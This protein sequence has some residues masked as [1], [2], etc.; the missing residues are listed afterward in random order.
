MNDSMK[1]FLAS[2]LAFSLIFSLLPVAPPVS[3]SQAGVENV[4]SNGDFEDPLGGVIGRGNWNSE[5]NRGVSRRSSGAPEGSFFLR[6][7]EPDT[8][9]AG[10]PPFIGVF[11]FNTS[12]VSAEP[13][14]R[15]AFSGLVRAQN[16]DP[17]D[18]AQMRIEFQTNTG[19]LLGDA[20]ASVTT[21]SS[22]FRRVTVTEIAPSGTQQITFTLRIGPFSNAGDVGGTTIV[23]FDDMTGTINSDPIHIDAEATKRVVHPGE[24]TMVSVRIQNQSAASL[25]DIEL[26]AEPTRGVNIHR[27]AAGLNG[28]KVQQ[29]ERNG[30]A[31]FTIGDMNAEQASL[32]AF[33]VV[34]AS[35]AKPGKLYDVKLFAKRK[36][37]EDALSNTVIVVIRVEEDPV[38]DQG[39]IIGKVFN[40]TNQNGFQDQGEKGVPWVRIV[41]E[42]GIVIITDEHGRYHIPAVKE[43]RHLVKIDGHTLPQGTK[44]I[45]EEAYLVKTTPGILNKANFAVLLPPSAI[46]AEFNKDLMVTV[47]QG[48]DTSRPNL[49][50]KM[51]PEMLKTGIGVLEKDAIFRFGAN[52]TDFIRKWYLE[53]R[54]QL[55]RSVWTG[56]GVGIPP[57]EVSWNGQTEALSLIRPGIYSYQFKVEDKGGRQ[58]WTALQFFRVISKTESFSMAKE[59][60]DIP[61]LGDFNIFKDGKQTIPLVAKPTIRI[62]GKTKPENQVSVNGFPVPV[63][64]QSGLFQTEVYASPGDKE[65]LVISTNPSGESTSYRETVKVKDSV[66]FMVALGEEQMGV[67]FQDGDLEAAGNDTGLRNGFYQDGR[68]SYYLRG[69]LKGKF[70]I[71][72]HYDTGDER[73]ALF[74][75]LDPDDYYPIYGDSSTRNYDAI[76]TEERFYFLIEMDRSFAKWGSFKTDFTDTELGSYNR[77][78]SGLKVSYDTVGT[79]PYGDPKRGFRLFWSKATHRADHN[80]F[81]STGGSLYYLRN[82]RVIEGSEKIRVEVRDKIQGIAISSHD[83]EEGRDYEIDYD[84]GRILLS[85]PLSSVAS[86]DTLV[87][88]DIL[89]GNPVLLVVDYEYDAGFR[90]FETE[91]R[92]LRGYTHVGD[93]LKVGAT[94][95]EEKRQN[96]DY[97]LRAV[98]ATLK[99]GRNTKIT[100]E[101]GE[102]IKQQT[103]QAVSFNGGL[104]FADQQ[105]L[106]GDN[107]RPRENA[108]VIKAQTKPMK[109]LEVAG[110]IQGVEPGF[111]IDRIRSQEGTKKYGL[112]STFRFTDYFYARYRY[113]YSEVVDQL[114]TL[115]EQDVF[116]PFLTRPTNTAQLV[117][118]DGKYLGE[119]EYLRQSAEVTPTNFSPSLTSEIPLENAIAAKVGYHVNDRLLPYV[120]VQTTIDGKAN[121]QFGGGIRYEVVK[122]LYA[123]IEEMVGNIGDSTY[124]GFERYHE[125]GARTYTNFK[126]FDRGIGTKTL[127][128]AIG[129]S[130]PLT[131][132]S[133]IF[134]ER[135][136][137]SY[138]S[139]DG[140]ADILGYEG[141]AGDHW[142]YEAKYERRH[143]DNPSTRRMDVE[144]NSSL[145]RTNTFNTISGALAYADH[146]KLRVRT[147]LEVRRDQDAPRV[148]QWVSRNSIEYKIT[149][150]WSVLSKLDYGKT[151]FLE[152]HDTP[153]DFMEFSSGFAY[154]PVAHDRLNMLGRYTYLR[155][156]SN[157]FQF[158]PDTLFKGIETNETAHIVA[159]DLGFDLN[160]YLGMVEKVAYK[161]SI[162]ESSISNEAIL[163]NILLAHRFN[164]HV[165]RKWDV[166]LEYRVL[167]QTDSAETIK[168]GALAEIDRE[169]YDYARLGIGY[170]FT[171]FSDDLRKIADYNSHG[172]FVRLTG[173]F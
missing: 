159:I 57:A 62:Q 123:Y 127:T 72:S 36:G 160:K 13:G 76:D 17:G 27:N 157:D 80:E 79:T 100:A 49:T 141:K 158:N 7:S 54:D 93:H 111:S 45:T 154:R 124:F 163:H 9:T 46:P 96:S 105:L 84:E 75:N 90:T 146:K 73:S 155:N 142:D 43:G 82:R 8:T 67:N 20:I 165:T 166:A 22:N 3:V 26:I 16:L 120:K 114:R 5:P 19:V 99:L 162:V 63:D 152:P 171:D 42:E 50:V 10:P 70:L 32:F 149:Q 106:H 44:F 33:P 125:G 101:Y 122:N 156:L 47:T 131:E 18:G 24:M 133:R 132:K 112:S 68:L 77:T 140:F 21:E 115:E 116:F 37:R 4:I 39:T 168:H 98:D 58:D 11:T 113:D 109:N 69:K 55:G 83:L 12:T 137:S 169:I 87:S 150:D 66:F 88:H 56:F 144:A 71:K 31:T 104:T 147:S 15:V 35:G 117:Y 103:E 173:K 172:P 148:M 59:K 53:I 60:I 97:D 74:T 145:L 94:V 135:E 110:Y 107:T 61:T 118:D 6:L 30:N 25:R 40:D 23:D 128:S 51:E 170:N 29:T 130:F 38:F 161:N 78:L 136:Q 34:V 85:R 92:G 153:A 48:L 108:Y 2:G 86:S 65:V 143:L 139:V 28:R 119:L 102:T 164:F 81:A 1:R 134:S 52:Y 64:S 95:V 138:N 14:D 89:D 151:Y 121:N 167:F 41:T 129:G 91:N 126:M